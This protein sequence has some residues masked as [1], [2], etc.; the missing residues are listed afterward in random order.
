MATLVD[1]LS[2]REGLQHIQRLAL[3]GA[4]AAS[5]QGTDGNVFSHIIDR[6]A[7]GRA[8]LLVKNGNLMIHDLTT[9]L[10]QTVAFPDGKT[11]LNAA[12]PANA[13]RAVTVADYTFLVN[14][15]AP[16]GNTASRA[17]SAPVNRGVVYVKQ[18]VA[19][20]VYRIT[21]DG[22]TASYTSSAT[23]KLEEIITGLL[24]ALLTALPSGYTFTEV[25]GV[26]ASN[27][28]VISIVRTSLATTVV[29]CSDSFGNTA[30]LSVHASVTDFS[31]L[32]ATLGTL[33]NFVT[34]VA[35]NPGND[36]GAYWVRWDTALAEY[37]ECASPG[38]ID[39]L[40]PATLPHR[41]V[42]EANGTYTL[43]RI[44]EWTKRKAGDDDSNPL[45]SF[46]GQ[47]LND[48]FFFR[49]RLGFLSQDSVTLSKA[50]K[51]FSFFGDSAQVVLDTDPID[52]SSTSE[53]VVE[54]LWAVPFN[55][56]LIVWAEKQQFVLTGGDVL[57]PKS[58][59]LA[60]STAF[61]AYLGV[62][63]EPLG[64]QCVF[65]TT[66]GDFTA[67][68]ML[69]VSRDTVTN[70]ADDLTDHVPRYLPPAPAQIEA[71]ST[72]KMLAVVP[73]E[74]GSVLYLLKYE[75]GAN[76]VWSQKAWSRVI[77]EDGIGQTSKIIRVHWVDRRLYVIRHVKDTADTS[78][79][80][81]RFFLELL[82]FQS[83]RQD[84][85]TDFSLRLDRKV[86]VSGGTFDGTVTQL[87]IPYWERAALKVLRCV[88]G[89]A[90][91][92]LQVV[93]TVYNT[94]GTMLV[95]VPGDQT[96]QTLWAGRSFSFRYRFSEIFMRDTNDAPIQNCKLALKRILLR[97][98]RTGFFRIRV[99]PYLREEYVYDYSGN[100]LGAI[101]LEAPQLATGDFSI[102][103]N[104]DPQ[105]TTVDIESDSFFPATF[106]YAE[107][108]GR[109]TMKAKR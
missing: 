52:L 70:Q 20:T 106:P 38:A 65:A 8:T 58:A 9:G 69:K 56:S 1:G 29:A 78:E 4:N 84:T 104:S 81:G 89:R 93:S 12:D 79:T 44:N 37:K 50:G 33:T 6:G 86:L 18:V 77:L 36:K 32:P 45:P 91:V 92:V 47:T 85:G 105:G 96:A 64:N 39:E 27:G 21:V 13:F 100:L 15:A 54:L 16:V 41:L 62:R 49:N 19:A 108:T 53:Q 3:T 22:T 60:P 31:N 51:Y 30:L 98:V 2:K 109:L 57:T 40:D 42:H 97:F 103:V 10:P 73:R 71:S 59:R 83:L 25:Q 61:E 95:S 43:S 94:D 11:Y 82:D 34:K 28:S 23:P 102:P 55:E 14:R 48:V 74:L 46:V 7:S 75:E 66:S 67:L 87:A 63:P 80:G 107:W 17:Q 26:G 68:R 88:V 35:L 24:G 99:R 72:A 90:P 101:P 76:A 5:V